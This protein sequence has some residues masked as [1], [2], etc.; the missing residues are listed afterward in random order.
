MREEPSR[1]GKPSTHRVESCST[2]SEHG[3]YGLV[4]C[5]VGNASALINGRFSL[6]LPSSFYASSQGFAGNGREAAGERATCWRLELPPAAQQHQRLPRQIRPRILSDLHPGTRHRRWADHQTSLRERRGPSFQ[7]WT[8]KSPGR[9]PTVQQRA[10]GGTSQVGGQD[11]ET[12]AA[13]SW[14]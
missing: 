9:S 11:V 7:R 2:V 12:H 4:T 10:D 13:A 8:R 3:N 6:S 1:L 5:L 14:P